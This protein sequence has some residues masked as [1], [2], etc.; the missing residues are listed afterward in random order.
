MAIDKRREG[1]YRLESPYKTSEAAGR[2]VYIC[3][4]RWIRRG[5]DEQGQGMLLRPGMSI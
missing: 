3:V 1:C 2:L 4:G 5:V